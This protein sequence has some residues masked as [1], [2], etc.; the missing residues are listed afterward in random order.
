MPRSVKI[1]V[2]PE[3][4]ERTKGS[5]FSST[6][7]RIEFIGLFRFGLGLGFDWSSNHGSLAKLYLRSG[8]P[9][10]LNTVDTY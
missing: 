7:G 3:V 8:F 4:A 1:T 6:K 5:V 2:D 10:H 9:N